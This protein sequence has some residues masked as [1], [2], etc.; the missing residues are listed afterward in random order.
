MPTCSFS[1]T[2]LTD[3]REAVP[4]S[5]I[6]DAGP[7]RGVDRQVHTDRPIYNM[8]NPAWRAALGMG[9]ACLADFAFRWH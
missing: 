7:C 4:L 9:D 2:P 6:V 5:T 3:H 8:I 1:R